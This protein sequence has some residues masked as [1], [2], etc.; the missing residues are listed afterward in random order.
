MEK[1]KKARVLGILTTLRKHIVMN[2]ELAH[3]TAKEFTKK[4]QI[5]EDANHEDIKE[6]QRGEIVNT[7]IYLPIE[8]TVQR[9][10]EGWTDTPLNLRKYGISVTDD[11]EWGYKDGI[12]YDLTDLIPNWMPQ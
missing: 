8:T 11:C 5:P 3:L 12:L 4:V 1:R 10:I 2:P 6:A 7:S 9:L